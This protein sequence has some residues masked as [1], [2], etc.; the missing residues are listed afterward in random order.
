MIANDAVGEH[1]KGV[2]RVAE[3]SAFTLDT[4]TATAVGMIHEDQFAAV[5]VRLFQRWKLPRYGPERFF[6]GGNRHRQK[7]RAEA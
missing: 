1:G 6:L 2:R 4:E 7:D 3:V 5:G